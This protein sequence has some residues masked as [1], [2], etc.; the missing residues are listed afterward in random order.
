MEA[1][2]ENASTTTN[3]DDTAIEHTA[4]KTRMEVEVMVVMVSMN[5]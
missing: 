4:I 5:E 2:G 1:H 3:D